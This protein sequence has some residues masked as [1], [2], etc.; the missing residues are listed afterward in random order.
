LVLQQAVPVQEE[1]RHQLVL[2]DE[3][4]FILDVQIPPGDTTL[5]HTHADPIF[6]VSIG[7]SR[8][9]SQVMGRDWVG[10]GEGLVSSPGRV[11]SN[12]RYA[13][14]PVTHRVNNVGD[15]LFRLIAVI[16]RSHGPSADS[17]VRS[18]RPIAM[19]PSGFE[20]EIDNHWFRSFRG[21]LEP[22]ASSTLHRH[23]LPVVTVQVA[24]GTWL[25]HIAGTEHRLENPGD[26]SLELV[27][28]EIR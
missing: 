25:F 24:D 21:T 11:F 14:R 28:I 19:L 7:T 10:P 15:G 22:G 6:Y 5:Y 4:A 1:P 20:V 18:P 23:A 16:N 3:V 8:T 9:R 13:D 12:I 2:D 26:T 27:E 17:A